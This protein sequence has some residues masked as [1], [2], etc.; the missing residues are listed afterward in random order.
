[1]RTIGEIICELI[2]AQSHAPEA[3]RGSMKIMLGM[4][5]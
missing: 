3:W 5:D 1:M 2:R 4:T